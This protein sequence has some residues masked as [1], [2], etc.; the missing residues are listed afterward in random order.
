MQ[1]AA[2]DEIARV[3]A[4][5]GTIILRHA[6]LPV[7]DPHALAKEVLPGKMSQRFARLDKQVVQETEFRLS[8][9]SSA[10]DEVQG[11][12]VPSH[13]TGSEGHRTVH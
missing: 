10:I 13:G 1:R 6:E 5:N 12:E 4:S 3:I 2:L 11:N 8:N 7:G 9:R